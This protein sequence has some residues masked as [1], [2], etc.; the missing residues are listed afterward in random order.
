MIAILTGIVWITCDAVGLGVWWCAGIAFVVGF[1]VRIIAL[2]R[3]WEEPLAKEPT[4]VYRHS[5]GRPLLG[6]KLKGKSVR[7]MRDLGLTD[8][9]GTSAP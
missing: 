7:E 9:T 8:E 5:D 2:Y 4:G 6:C 1:T 3:G